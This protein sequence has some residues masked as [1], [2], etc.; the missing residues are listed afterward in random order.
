MKQEKSS[1]TSF[2]LSIPFTCD[3]N[4]LFTK[5]FRMCLYCCCCLMPQIHTKA[6]IKKKLYS[7]CNIVMKFCCRYTIENI[8]AFKFIFLGRSLGFLI[9]FNAVHNHQV[10]NCFSY[11][12]FLLLFYFL[13]IK[14]LKIINSNKSA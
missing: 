4:M 12:F 5:N 9:K 1:L 11:F 2:A 3:S 7:N 10:E 8:I 14:M 6:Y 13:E